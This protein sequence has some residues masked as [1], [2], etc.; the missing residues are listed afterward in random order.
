MFEK[1]KGLF[2]TVSVKNQKLSLGKWYNQAVNFFTNTP[3]TIIEQGYRKNPHVYSVINRIIRTASRIRIDLFKEVNGEP[4]KVTEHLAKNL[5]NNPNPMQGRA[6]FFEGLLGWKLAVGEV[7]VHLLWPDMGKNARQ[8]KEMY[9]IPPMMVSKINFDTFGEIISYEVGHGSNATI[10][11]A[12]EMIHIKYW[13]PDSKSPRG[14]SPISAALQSLQ[15]SNDDQLSAEEAGAVQQKF[16][17]TYGGVDNKGKIIVTGA[18][19]NWEAIGLSPVDLEL[20]EQQK[21]SLRDICNVYGLSSR[22]FNDPEANNGSTQ[23][24]VRIDLIVNVAEPEMNSVLE[25]FNRGIL[26][27]FKGGANLIYKTNLND[28]QE[29]KADLSEQATALNTAWWLTPNQKLSEMGLETSDL[30]EMDNVYIPSG[31]I[32]ID[33]NF[34]DLTNAHSTE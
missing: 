31:V 6:E 25:E 8:P 19:L 23:K 34:D 16:M 11:D 15:T 33:A 30:K 1:I 14:M 5:I 22:L 17:E 10:I 3:E 12:K 24:E 2:S 13:N 32:P 21:M 18:S 7:F 26:P 28:F 29:L 20:L 27:L 9:I 4:E